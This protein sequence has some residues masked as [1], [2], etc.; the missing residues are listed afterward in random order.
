M[1]KLTRSIVAALVVAIV[2]PTAVLAYWPVGTRSSYVS[3]WS[4][5]R[6]R[7]I[8]IAATAGVKVLPIRS[9]KTVFAGYKNNCGGY[10]VWLSH[11]NGLYSAYYP[12]RS[13]TSYR[14]EY[15]SGGTEIIGY[16]GRTGCASGN[17]LHIEVWRG[18]PWASGSY[19]V[20]PWNYIDDG[21]YLPYRY[22]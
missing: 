3:Q 15:V 4:S 20:N 7:A 17:H 5:S 1:R 19:R 2:L 10:Q 21:Y 14:G 13:E 9:G 8:D 18:Y 16:L 11:G 12:L 6:H 22:R